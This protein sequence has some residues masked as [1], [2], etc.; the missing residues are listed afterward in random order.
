MNT[1]SWFLVALRVLLA[2]GLLGLASCDTPNNPTQPPLDTDGDGTP[3][4]RDACVSLPGD[5]QLNGCP[6]YMVDV[7]SGA[8]PNTLNE[9]WSTLT[10]AFYY[11]SSLPTAWRAWVDFGAMKWNE[12]GSRLRIKKYSTIVSAGVA[13]DQKSVICY[14]PIDNIALGRCYT[15]INR[16]N[17]QVV[18]R[19]IKLNSNMPLLVGASPSG[20]DLASVLTHE[21]G[22]FC[23]LGHVLDQTHTMYPSI[24]KNC[25]IYRTLCAGD[26]A[27]LRKLYP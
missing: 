13:N 22:H 11:S 23:G 24:P 16:S 26:V 14:G 12:A 7:C 17:G 2:A 5:A 27:G 3:D 19:D 20:Y 21:F 15:W 25:T 8:S 1:H 9:K 6:W 10:P 18:E 4:S